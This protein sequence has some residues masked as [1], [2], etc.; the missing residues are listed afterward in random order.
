MMNS[1]RGLAIADD[2]IYAADLNNNRIDIFTLNGEFAWMFGEKGDK[3]GQF[4][5]P[6][7]VAVDKQ[8]NIYVAD[9]W[10]GRIEKFNP[11]GKFELEIGGVKAG[12]YSPRNVAVNDYGVIHVADT[13]TSRIHRF[14][15]DGNRIGKAFGERGKAPGNF[16]EVFGLA[17]DSKKRVYVADPGNR[18]ISVLS[19][20]LVPQA[21]IKI[22]P[23]DTAAPMW[24]MIAID[25]NDRLYVVSSGTQEIWVYDT[26]NPKFKYLGTIKTDRNNKMLLANPLG[27]AID[28]QD[29]VYVSEVS[30]SSIIKIKPV[31]EQ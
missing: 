11:K 14:D 21:T 30:K 13:G 4:K 24:P 19:S 26:K 3:K 6:S 18:R 27:I 5:E 20:D 9:A 15:T 7:G 8:G 31:F 17:F 10:N 29:N 2:H 22:K 12:F 25:S 16:N 23:W 1:P 28:Q